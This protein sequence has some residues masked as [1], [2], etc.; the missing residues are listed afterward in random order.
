M[1]MLF[2]VQAYLFC[3]SI[4]QVNNP[5]FDD[6]GMMEEQN[7]AMVNVSRAHSPVSLM[8]GGGWMAQKGKL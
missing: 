8:K 3:L 2:Y 4:G 5:S 6:Y 1:F 7:A